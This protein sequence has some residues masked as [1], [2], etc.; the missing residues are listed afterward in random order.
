MTFHLES[1]GVPFV[2]NRYSVK[3]HIFYDCT[4][5]YNIKCII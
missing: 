1:A 4:D 2:S 5:S 3:F